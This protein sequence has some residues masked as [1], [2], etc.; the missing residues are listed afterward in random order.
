[1]KYNVFWKVALSNLADF[2][3]RI[4]ENI[5]LRNVSK[6]Y[7]DLWRYFPENSTFRSH[8]RENLESKY[9]YIYVFHYNIN[10]IF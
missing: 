3:R 10:C 4:G 1:M 2:Y 8:L 6:V 9:I 7:Q 5:F